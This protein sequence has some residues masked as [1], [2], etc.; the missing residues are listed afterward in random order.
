MSQQISRRTLWSWK[1]AKLCKSLHSKWPKL[2]FRIAWFLSME[3]LKWEF[4]TFIK[5]NSDADCILL[6]LFEPCC[7]FLCKN[8][9]KYFSLCAFFIFPKGVMNSTYNNSKCVCCRY[10]SNLFGQWIF[11][12]THFKRQWTC[13]WCLLPIWHNQWY[14]RECLLPKAWNVSKN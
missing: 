13:N 6:A 5:S 4:R 3:N 1:R 12:Y 14:I 10:Q 7:L 2:L 11:N 9:G 8:A